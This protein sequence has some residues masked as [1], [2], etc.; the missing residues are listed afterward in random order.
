MVSLGREARAVW[1]SSLS[2]CPVLVTLSSS[3][4]AAAL[5]AFSLLPMALPGRV[6]VRIGSAGVGRTLCCDDFARGGDCGGGAMYARA[7]YA[8]ASC[9]NPVGVGA[10]VRR[11]GP[12]PG[13]GGLYRICFPGLYMMLVYRCCAA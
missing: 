7:M 2:G 3:R 4:A 9:G 8:R 6:V 12:Q 11:W 13:G 5:V 1:P 10:G